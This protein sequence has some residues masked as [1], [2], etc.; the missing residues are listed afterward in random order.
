MPAVEELLTIAPPPARR[1]AGV[2]EQRVEL[3]EGVLGSRHRSLPV[4]RI[5]DVETPVA[6]VRAE[7]L[8]QGG[9]LV[10]QDVGDHH[11]CAAPGQKPRRCAANAP[12]PAGDQ[13][14]EILDLHH[15]LPLPASPSMAAPARNYT[16]RTCRSRRTR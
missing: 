1:I 11:P 13:D 2:V 6:R 12:R 16:R 10:V 5:G 15:H 4:R 7:A 14:C 9:A 3:A 8:C